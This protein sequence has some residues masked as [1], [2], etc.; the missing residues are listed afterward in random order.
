MHTKLTLKKTKADE[1]LISFMMFSV[2]RVVALFSNW[3][4]A[5]NQI[6][7]PKRAALDIGSHP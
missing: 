6:E 1:T 2:M 5:R 3:H 4:T 7:F